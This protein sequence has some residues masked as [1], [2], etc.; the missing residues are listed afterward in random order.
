[1]ELVHYFERPT[2]LSGLDGM[3][4]WMEMF[5]MYLFKGM[6]AIQV[7]NLIQKAAERL[8]P[9]HFINGQWWAD[10]RRLRIKAKKLA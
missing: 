5:A 9:T 4:N 6:D 3:T 7:E 10:Y 8:R 1:V 2:K